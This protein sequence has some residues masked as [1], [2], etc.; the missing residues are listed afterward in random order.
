MYSAK[1]LMGALAASLADNHRIGYRAAY[2]IFGALAD[3]NAFAIGA[4]LIDPKAKIYLSWLS[5]SDN[6]WN[7]AL[8]DND[9][10]IVS[11]PDINRPES[12][13]REYGI[14]E[15]KE[16][17]EIQNLAAPVIN[18]GLYYELILRPVVEGY[19]ARK[20]DRPDRAINYWWGMSAGVVDIRLA[21]DL[22]YYSRKLV[23][24]MGTSLILGKLNPFDGE[25]HSTE[26]IVKEAGTPRLA[27]EE[28]I[29]MNW[30]NDNIIGRIPEREE[31]PESVWAKIEVSGV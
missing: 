1:F 29:R 19:A 24:A 7:R 15:R 25:L 18:W 28:I 31:L 12:V 13:S 2:P 4:G 22:D 3:I 27:N 17:G 23:N 6:D 5:T 11:G 14:Y 21:D 9:I 30:L 8:E 20:T 16:N 26:G 10:R